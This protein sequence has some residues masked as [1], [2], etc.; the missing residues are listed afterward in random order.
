MGSEHT[1][2]MLGAIIA[3]VVI[4]GTIFSVIALFKKLPISSR[5]CSVGAIIV[6]VLAYMIIRNILSAML[7][8]AIYYICF[9][10]IPRRKSN[11][12]KYLGEKVQDETEE[13]KK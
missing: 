13:E 7:A 8:G 1:F 3:A 6:L 12:K 4:F 9:Y 11:V 2:I 5:G 10:F